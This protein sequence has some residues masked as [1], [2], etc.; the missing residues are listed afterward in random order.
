MR[1]L[2][3]TPY[4]YPHSGGS[5]NYIANLYSTLVKKHPEIVVDVVCYNTDKSSKREVHKS[6]NVYRVGCWEILP[7]QF[8]L[9]NYIELFSLIKKL[10]AQKG[11]YDLVNAHTRFFDNC[12]WSPFVA[13][14]LG[15]KSVLTDHCAYSPKHSSKV[16]TAITYA[17]D[18]LVTPL[19]A[20]LYD[21]VVVV[22]AAT[23]KYLK[24][25]NI[26]ADKV[27]YGGVDTKYFAKVSLKKELLLPNVGKKFDKEDIVVTFLGR[28]IYSKG[29][30]ILLEAAKKIVAEFDNVFFIFAG[31]GKALAKLRSKRAS[32]VYFT[33]NLSQEEVKSLL[34]RT[35]ILVLPTIH[36]EGFPLTLLE[37]GASGCAVIATNQ[38]GIGELIVDNETG[39]IVSPTAEDVRNKLLMLINDKSLRVELAGNLQKKV[40]AKFDW[41]IIAEN[42]YKYLTSF[43]SILV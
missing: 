32:H 16:V 19:V 23:K 6:L 29:P 39:L 12:L 15:A 41:N 25:L 28:M 33:G 17:I 2:V 13:K 3:T 22:S 42:F 26:K 37:A 18:N 36:H 24:K 40:G 31:K 30:Q 20:R 11:S 9:P 7:G 10:K 35:D 1:V 38:G 4:F 8:A 5:Q 14:Y 27:F 21:D 43:T 34:G